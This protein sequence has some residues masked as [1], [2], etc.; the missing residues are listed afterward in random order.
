M[1]TVRIGNVS[2]VDMKTGMVSVVYHDRE[3]ETTGYLPYFSPGEEWKPPEVEDMVVVVHLSNGTTKGIVIGKFWNKGNIP[4]AIGKA[5]WHKK[6]ADKAELRYEKETDTLY[7]KAPHIVLECGEK[8][9]D[10]NEWG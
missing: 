8:I 5:D 3:D 1:E 10:V 6:L 7:I 2:D 9:I 4:P